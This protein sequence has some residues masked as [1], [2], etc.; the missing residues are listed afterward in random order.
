MPA[1]LLA[2]LPDQP[3]VSCLIDA[4]QRVLIGRAPECQLR[5][6]HPSVSRR[7]A[8]LKQSGRHWEL[9][10]LDSKNGSFVNG[11]HVATSEIVGQ[12]WLRFGDVACQLTP[13]T[14][15]ETAHVRRRI[16]QRRQ[17]SV[18]MAD[19]LERQTVLPELLQDTLRAV[20]ELA[21]AERGFL[22]I[23]EENGLRVA[24]THG[25]EAGSLVR[26]E[27]TGS[28]GA[29]E[30]A[31]TRRE[32]VVANELSADSAL[33]RR[34]SVIHGGLNMLVCVPLFDGAELLGVVYADSRRPGAAISQLDLDLLQAF[35]SR[36]ALWIAARR[37]A[38]ALE[39]MTNKPHWGD[40]LV[41]HA[42][43]HP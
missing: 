6:D 12:G 32:P 8:E 41:A 15:E 36:A 13:L 18:D 16:D 31:I 33:G 35:T 34:P 40:I 17:N 14:D 2:F 19:R 4:E 21:D 20:C 27:F 1:Q 3:A 26:R 29:V 9:T 23:A 37:E 7:H 25:L 10:D 42:E 39:A 24:A 11:R 43:N 5:L 30:R 38:R 28:V 22:L